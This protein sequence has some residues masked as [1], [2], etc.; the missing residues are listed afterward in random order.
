MRRPGRGKKTKNTWLRAPKEKIAEE[1]RELLIRLKKPKGKRGSASRIPSERRKE[2]SK[3]AGGKNKNNAPRN[4]TFR[5]GWA[6]VRGLGKCKKIREPEFRGKNRLLPV[7]LKK[8][9]TKREKVLNQLSMM[10]KKR[11]VKEQFYPSLQ[12][13]VKRSIE[14]PST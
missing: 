6:Y 7:H 9:T 14:T 10:G 8:E 12:K 13:K 2:R 1:G 11:S 4:T 5:G 3:Y